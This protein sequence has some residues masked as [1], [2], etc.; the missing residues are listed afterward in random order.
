MSVSR[1]SVLKGAATISAASTLPAFAR[2]APPALIV[3]D[4]RIP[5]SCAFAKG[6][7]LRLDIVGLDA[8]RWV[9]LRRELP[10]T[11][12]ISGLTGWSDWVVARGL[13]EERG[14]RLRSET[15]TPA[16]MSRKA[17]LFRWEMG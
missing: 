4:S 11:L 6:A 9:A 15:W 7:T 14:F 17:H 2:P 8:S 1:R 10:E 3:F 5:E 16:P 13:L 12:Q